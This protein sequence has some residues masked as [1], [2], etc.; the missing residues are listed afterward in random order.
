MI[1]ELAN[2]QL[3]HSLFEAQAQRT[4]SARAVVAHDGQ[5]SYAELN[6]RSNQ[7][8]HYL[9]SLGIG[10]ETRAGIALPRSAEMIVAALAVLKAGGAY[11][12]IDPGYPMQRFRYLAEDSRISVL[13][14]HRAVPEGLNLKAMNV[15]PL[16]NHWSRVTEGLE[17]I[18][19]TKTE[20]SNLAYLIYT[21]GSTGKP[22]GVMISHENAIASTAARTSYYAL[23]PDRFLLLSSFSFDSSVA[24]IFWTLLTGGELWLPPEGTQQ[25][26]ARITEFVRHGSITHLLALPS[27]YKSLLLHATNNQLRSLRTVIVAGE[28]CPADLVNAHFHQL[29]GASLFN[30]YGPTE[31]TVWC[32]VYKTTPAHQSNSIPIGK[33]IANVEAHILDPE[34]KPVVRGEL[35]ELYIGG[36]QL[37]RGYLGQPDL[38]AER[39]LPNPSAEVPGARLYRTGDLARFGAD[40]NIDF[41]GRTDQQVK[42]RGHR[43]ELGEIE[44]ALREHPQ[45]EEAVVTAKSDGEG[46]QKLVA[47][48]VPGTKEIDTPNLRRF[49]SQVLP[50]YMVPTAYV[51]LDALPLNANGKLDRQALPDPKPAESQ[52]TFI[53]PRTQ[54]EQ[55]LAQ[56]WAELLRVKRVG[57]HDNFFELGG[58][59]ILGLQ[60]VAR[61]NQAGIHLNVTQV[62]EQPTIGGLASHCTTEV[63]A[64]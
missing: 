32:T 30:E 52:S 20:S 62:T 24:T 10:P 63:S 12:P 25:N 35:G 54:T 44:S 47:Y 43:I 49:L 39:F 58:D 16:E 57:I 64:K 28:P 56:I 3:L 29:P 59:S 34:M 53:A 9:Q 60:M 38:T 46:H 4:P 55:R 2:S 51:I 41:L 13:L 48:V 31:A 14:T 27:L 17:H 33:P 11:V 36:P 21:S 45:I 15:V 7:L 18:P 19:K 37:A 22:K 8:A 26:V 1:S 42:I 40:D 23:Q 6:R 61:A 5:F 50:G